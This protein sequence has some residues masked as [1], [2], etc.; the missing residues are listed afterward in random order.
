MKQSIS[1]FKTLSYFIMFA[2]LLFIATHWGTVWMVEAGDVAPFVAWFVCG[3]TVF[4]ALFATALCR[5]TKEQKSW[6]LE[7]L[8]AAL[9]LRRMRGRD[10]A[11]T[12]G[13]VVVVSVLSIGMMKVMTALSAHFPEVVAA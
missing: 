2:V 8:L 11:W 10:W 5:V 7:S 13:G 6:R 3:E 9:N 1:A 4:V 12:M